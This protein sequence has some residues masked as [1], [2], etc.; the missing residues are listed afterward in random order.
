LDV[1][2]RSFEIRD[3]S[4]APVVVSLPADAPRS[5]IERFRALR[6]GDYVRVEGRFLDRQRFEL[7]SFL[8]DNR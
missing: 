7:A 6:D 2:R 5:D 4:G 3:Q 1:Q 8:R